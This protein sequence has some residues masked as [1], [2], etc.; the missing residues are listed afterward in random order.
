MISAATTQ[1]K[2]SVNF[3]TA[4]D[5]GAKPETSRGAPFRPPDPAYPSTISAHKREASIGRKGIAGY[6]QRGS[7]RNHKLELHA[8]KTYITS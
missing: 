2:I 7:F 8:P 5:G 3:R 6:F 1:R 4:D